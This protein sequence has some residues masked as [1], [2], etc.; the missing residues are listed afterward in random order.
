MSN[1][2]LFVRELGVDFSMGDG[3]SMM[4]SCIRQLS[5]KLSTTEDLNE[6]RQFARDKKVISGHLSK[7]YLEEKL[8]NCPTSSIF[9][10]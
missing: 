9:P 7:H 6:L 8:S 4:T 10:A 2:L 3:T 1:Y 5:T